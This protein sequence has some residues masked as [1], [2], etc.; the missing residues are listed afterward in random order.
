[1]T[2]KNDLLKAAYIPAI[3]STLFLIIPLT[4][5]LLSAGVNWGFFDFIFAWVLLFS[6]GFTYKYIASRKSNTKYKAALAIAVFTSLFIVWSNLAV[7][8]IGSEDN[9][10]N[11]IYFVMLFAVIIGGV[12]VKFHPKGLS[13]LMF[14]AAAAHG[15]IP[16]IAFVL[17]GAENIERFTRE[18][19]VLIG[20]HLFIIML[21]TI[22]GLLFRYSAQD[23]LKNEEISK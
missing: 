5:M 23:K 7:G 13:I 14:A 2:A 12:A 9:P 16:F 8:I 19:N 4:G 18:M 11:L 6:A 3:A 15:L 10:V 17:I 1:M 22:S 21:W 20:I